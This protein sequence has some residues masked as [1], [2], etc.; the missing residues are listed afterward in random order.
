MCQRVVCLLEHAYL[1]YQEAVLRMRVCACGWM[2][3]QMQRRMYAVWYVRCVDD[4]SSSG[5]E[6][7]RTDW[8]HHRSNARVSSSNLPTNQNFRQSKEGRL[9]T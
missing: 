3:G 4:V 7:R 1:L 6:R 8:S 9:Y 5:G 2:G